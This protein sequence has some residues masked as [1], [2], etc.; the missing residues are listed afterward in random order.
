[1]SEKYNEKTTAEEVAAAYRANIE[2]KVVAIT[3][4]T[5]GGIGAETARVLASN[6]A[7]LIFVTGRKQSV[8]DETIK[9]ILEESPNANIKGVIMDLSSF[10]SVRKAAAEVNAATDQV[11]VIINNAG[12]MAMPYAKSTDGYEMQFATNHLGHFLWTSLLKEKLFKSKAP[13]VVNLSS[14]ATLFAPV[15][16]DDINFTNGKETYAPFVSYGQSKTANILFTRELY[17]LYKDAHNLT[18]FAV[19]PGAVTTNLTRHTGTDVQAIAANKDYWGNPVFDEEKVKSLYWKNV[20]EGSATTMAAAF[21]DYIAPGSYLVDCQ[22]A[23]STLYSYA[24]DKSNAEKLWKVS[25]EF[26]GQKF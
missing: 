26:I 3:G 8:L 19:H 24:T 9:K 14:V 23:T 10:E 4:V 17:D 11:D 21:G 22:D 1:M 18:A 12:V 6:G 2:G 13:R 15:L 7:K 5:W 16:F 20:G 25:E